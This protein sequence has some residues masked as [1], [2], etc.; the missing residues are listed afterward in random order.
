MDLTVRTVWLP[1]WHKV[2]IT[3]TVAA[4]G[5]VSLFRSGADA[6]G[7][8]DIV[9]ATPISVGPYPT[10]EIVQVQL[11]QGDASFGEP[12]RYDIAALDADFNAHAAA[13]T[14]QDFSGDGVPVDYTDGDP[15]ATGEGVAEIGARYTDYI[16]GG[17]KAQPV[18]KL[19]T[20][21]T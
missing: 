20:S 16:N 15:A 3:P 5:N 13:R 18:W 4:A 21:A 2:G 8:V 19:V 1:A 6:V 9:G 17:T 11:S 10:D 7:L 14:V 12:T